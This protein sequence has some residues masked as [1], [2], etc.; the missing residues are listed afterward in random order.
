MIS[1]AMHAAQARYIAQ[2]SALLEVQKEAVHYKSKALELV[3]EIKTRRIALTF[4][5]LSLFGNDAK[6]LKDMHQTVDNLILGLPDATTE[7]YQNKSELL[8]HI[9]QT[10]EERLVF[11]KHYIGMIELDID[12]VDQIQSAIQNK[13]RE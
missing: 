1:A 10:F 2:A 13:T 5:P 12:H 7:W 8:E 4:V 11:L 3:E 6:L 9:K